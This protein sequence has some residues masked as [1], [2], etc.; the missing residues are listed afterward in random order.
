[1]PEK[2][3]HKAGIK[4]TFEIDSQTQRKLAKQPNALCT[5]V[6]MAVAVC[7]EWNTRH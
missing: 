1:M 6:T 5:L 2:T 4:L 7:L 3:K